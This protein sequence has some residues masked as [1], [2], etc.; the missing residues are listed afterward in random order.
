MCWGQSK[1]PTN[2]GSEAEKQVRSAREGFVQEAAPAARLVK[3]S[4]AP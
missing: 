2:K 4:W 3:D 1:E